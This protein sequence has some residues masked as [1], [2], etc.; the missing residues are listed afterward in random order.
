MHLA[1]PL[2]GID[3]DDSLPLSPSGERPRAPLRTTALI[4][5][6]RGTGRLQGRHLNHADRRGRALDARLHSR[7]RA[8]GGAA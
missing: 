7:G 8:F 5:R 6:R 2:A 4:S 1:A 3:T